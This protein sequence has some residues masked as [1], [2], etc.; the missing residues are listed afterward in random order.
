MGAMDIPLFDLAEKRLAW[1]DRR[2]EV[3]AQNIANA[4][5]PSWQSQDLVP[6]SAMLSRTQTIGLARTQANHLDGVGGGPAPVK[7]E[8]KPT[9]RSPNG[10]TVTLDEQLTKVADTDTTQALVSNLYKTY[11]S[12]FRTAIGRGS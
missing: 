1:A 6:F 7:T 12:M 4:N 9:S 5:T 3:L 2:Q 8:A 11:L 10:N